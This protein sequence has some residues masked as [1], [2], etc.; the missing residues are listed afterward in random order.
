M[1]KKLWKEAFEWLKSIV[2]ALVIVFAIQTFFIPTMVSGQSMYPTLNENDVLLIYKLAYLND[3]PDRGDII[4]FK[5]DILD[6]KTNENKNLI[7]RVIALPNERITIKDNKIFINDEHLNESYLEGID[8]YGD[9]DIIV[10]DGH[11]FVLGDNRGHSTDSRSP[12]VGTVPLEDIIGKA[13]IR[14]FPFNKIS[15]FK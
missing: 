13:F 12:Y 15:N 3:L 2:I 9:I 1:N 6:E 10:P 4:V 5:S 14:M 8:T 7:K 11:I